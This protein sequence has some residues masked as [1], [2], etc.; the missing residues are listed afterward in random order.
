MITLLSALVDRGP[1]GSRFS[2]TF[3]LRTEEAANL[4]D[5]VVSANL[6]QMAKDPRG[7]RGKFF[8]LRGIQDGWVRYKRADRK[9]HW[10][11][12]REMVE[13]RDRTGV[14]R[15]DCEDFAAAVAA[16]LV[17]NGIDARTYVYKST[18]GL[19]HVVVKTQK[20]GLLDPARGAGMGGNG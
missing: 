2:P 16:E 17:A 8:L 15:G 18:P 6:S 4:L 14:V 11:T 9:E 5:G 7:A 12:W 10:Q 13:Q 19:Y 3:H 20:W 1:R